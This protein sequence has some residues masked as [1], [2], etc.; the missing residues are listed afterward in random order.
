[1][2]GNSITL[3]DND[4]PNPK[5]IKPNHLYCFFKY[6]NISE[7]CWIDDEYDNFRFEFPD[8]V[9]YIDLSYN[10]IYDFYEGKTENYPL[11]KNL[12][13]L[14]LEYNKLTTLPI[15]PSTVMAFKSNN[16]FI[17]KIQ[18]IPDDILI[19]NLSSNNIREWK[20]KLNKIKR[21]YLNH[22]KL[23]TFNGIE[24]EISDTLQELHLQNNLL[25]E[26]T[27]YT[28]GIND[29]LRHLDLSNNYLEKIP[30]LNDGLEY[31]N[32]A[33]NK[34][35]K[36]SYYPPSL[37]YIN[38]E[39]NQLRRLS[40]TI[41]NCS[42]LQSLNYENNY[43]IEV[44]FEVL[45]FIEKQ[46]DKVFEEEEKLK[47]LELKKALKGKSDSHL[48]IS[49]FD[50]AQNVHNVKIRKDI[51]NIIAKLFEEIVPPEEYDWENVKE[52]L[53]DKE[54]V[55]EGDGILTYI[56]DNLETHSAS[57]HSFKVSFWDVLVRIWL[58]GKQAENH[59]GF[60]DI[61]LREIADGSQVCFTGK[62][63]KMVSS[64]IGIFP[65]FKISVN[66]QDEIISRYNVVKDTLEK[67]NI[68]PDTLCYSISFLFYF[69]KKLKDL[70]LDKK[71]Q[72]EWEEPLEERIEDD[73]LTF[74]E[75]CGDAIINIIPKIRLQPNIAKWFKEKYLEPEKNNLNITQ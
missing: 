48:L 21:L 59:S 29:N 9:E 71:Q 16:N 28:S 63:S 72:Q 5:V 18:N 31:L 46:F 35:K 53:L 75:K 17:D 34:L 50:N 37:K 12:K 30:D 42:S 54:Y 39:D 7:L 68:P 6:C 32:V 26:I 19:L 73:I 20:F 69:R 66:I 52:E 56:E 38:V 44:S 33:N 11:P 36:I 22:N 74:E 57:E 67:Q 55:K 24:A 41:L 62:V 3:F 45:E 4:L 64:L 8:W 65:E 58:K 51:Q 27:S 14:N 1:M 15:I 70:D 10:N 25:K 47:A 13:V 2:K 43:N 49:Y 40:N 23:S 61:L 60:V